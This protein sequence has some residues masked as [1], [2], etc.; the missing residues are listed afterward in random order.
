MSHS[1]CTRI[2]AGSRRIP[3]NAWRRGNSAMPICGVRR[4]RHA[5]AASLSG[6][7]DST[8]AVARCGP[9]GAMPEARNR[10]ASDVSDAWFVP[11]AIRH[12]CA[13]MPTRC[14]QQQLHQPQVCQRGWNIRRRCRWHGPVHGHARARMHGGPIIKARS[15]HV[16]G[17]VGRKC[18]FS[19][20]RSGQLQGMASLW[21][22]VR[23]HCRRTALCGQ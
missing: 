17:Q 18:R 13:C 14:C 23:K 15:R 6:V 1:L 11:S 3:C 12:T 10:A 7:G 4:T 20:I 5:L 19:V 2:S 16:D 21:P 22:H 9:S 8:V